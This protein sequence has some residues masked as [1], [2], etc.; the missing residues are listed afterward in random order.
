MNFYGFE[1]VLMVTHHKAPRGGFGVDDLLSI[2]NL[3]RFVLFSEYMLGTRNK[4]S[5]GYSDEL[6]L[7][8]IYPRTQQM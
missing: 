4:S 1:T 2:V 7:F 8:I 6:Y 3:A 5:F